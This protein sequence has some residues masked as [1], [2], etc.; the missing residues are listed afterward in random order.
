M[1]HDEVAWTLNVLLRS[2]IDEAEGFEACSE[3]VTNLKLQASL[4]TTARRCRERAK[5]L[6]RKIRSLGGEPA[7]CGSANGSLHRVWID[8]K[9][10]IKGMG[11][12]AILAECERAEE[13]AQD[14]YETALGQNLPPD[15]R[16]LVEEQYEAIIENHD[17]FR[18][19]RNALSH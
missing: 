9:A 2:A 16:T 11:D 5:E 13:A 1:D 12:E 18:D 7:Q 4:E 3:N 8:L 17:L 15:S 10:C 6:E 14:Q 19:L